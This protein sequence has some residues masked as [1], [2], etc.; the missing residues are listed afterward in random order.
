MSTTYG[1]AVPIFPIA[2]ANVLAI[3]SATSVRT[4]AEPPSRAKWN[5]MKG[6]FP[7]AIIK[8]CC[9]GPERYEAL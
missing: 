4:G 6:L 9:G 5:P 8:F 1:T 3:A 7:T 2:L